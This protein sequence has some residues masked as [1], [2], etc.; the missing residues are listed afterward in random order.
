M[1]YLQKEKL[2][3]ILKK[4]LFSKFVIKILNF[5]IIINQL[6]TILSIF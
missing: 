3:E 5:L 6:Q 2:G 4:I 1:K